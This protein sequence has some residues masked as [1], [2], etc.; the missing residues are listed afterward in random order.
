MDHKELELKSI[1]YRKT[2]LDIIDSLYF[3]ENI[4]VLG[5]FN[6]YSQEDPIQILQSTNLNR[7][8][9]VNHSYIYKGK[10]GSLDHVFVSCNFIDHIDQV[11][12][13]NINSIYPSWMDYSHILADSSYF[14]S[15]DHNPMV[16]GINGSVR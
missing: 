14:R 2:I 10:N 12:T 9:T 13:L 5:D 15:S 8:E 11:Q 1:E 6:A 16:V 4:I 3:D 7:L